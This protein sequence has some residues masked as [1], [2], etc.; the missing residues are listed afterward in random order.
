MFK[1][2]EKEQEQE[3]YHWDYIILDSGPFVYNG[4]VTGFWQRRECNSC[5]IKHLFSYG[6]GSPPEKV[7]SAKCCTKASKS[8]TKKEEK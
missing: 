7:E 8:K 1:K 2:K 5:G 3:C 6:I 4:Q